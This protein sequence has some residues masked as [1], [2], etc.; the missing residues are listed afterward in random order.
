MEVKTQ[1]SDWCYDSHHRLLC[2]TCFDLCMCPCITPVWINMS[3]LLFQIATEG[4][5]LVPPRKS[6]ERFQSEKP[7]CG[8]NA[9]LFSP[10]PLLYDT[11]RKEQIAYEDTILFDCL[12][13]LLFWLDWPVDDAAV[14]RSDSVCLCESGHI[15]LKV[16]QSVHRWHLKGLE[17]RN[18][19]T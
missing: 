19:C 10:S 16:W 7:C 12:C 3:A 18:R 6:L 14:A 15:L 13:V 17:T 1:Y 5:T 8:L 2:Q 4:N 9:F 11:G